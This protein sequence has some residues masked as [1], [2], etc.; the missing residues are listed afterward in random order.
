MPY[1]DGTGPFGD[2]R[3]GRGLGPCGRFGTR[4]RYGFGRG[5]GFGRRGGFGFRGRGGYP[6]ENYGYYS[7]PQA[8][9][10]TKDDLQAQK[11][12]LQRQLQ[13][14]EDQLNKPDEIK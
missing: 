8:Y 1:H 13:W 7:A 10:Y 9:P 11:E 6:N 3:P 2:G 12:D 14:I 5:L 4:V